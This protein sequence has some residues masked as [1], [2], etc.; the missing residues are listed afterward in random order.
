MAVQSLDDL[1]EGIRS[2]YGQ[3]FDVA[4]HAIGDKAVSQSLEAMAMARK[5]IPGHWRD[6]L[7]HVQL[8]NKGD[9]PR[10]KKLG[11]VASVQPV[12]LPTDWEVAEKR[13][14]PDRC[15][16]GGYAWKTLLDSGIP[17]QFGS[18]SPV[19]PNNPVLGLQAAVTRQTPQGE[20]EGGW[21]PE[22]R[23][24]LLAG[25]SGYTRTAAWSARREDKL[26]ILSPGMLADLTIFEKDLLTVPVQEWPE[27]AVEMTVIDGETVYCKP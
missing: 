27:I 17:L 8:L 3:G 24:D 10:F 23:L 15:R 2:A 20:P 1:A 4:V 6:R 16:R 9:I 26:G 22:Q 18:D 14:G 25:I 19:E 11:V 7:E 21:Y 13:W 12:F 5:T